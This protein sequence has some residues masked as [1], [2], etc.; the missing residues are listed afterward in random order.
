MVDRYS[1]ST[2]ALLAASELEE[3]LSTFRLDSTWKKS[4]LAFMNTWTTMV[5]DLDN[6]LIH[7]T[8]KSQK[9]I[10]LVRSIAPKALLA[11]SISQFKASEK[12]TKF[13][14]GTAY[15]NAPFSTL[16]DHVK[17]D[18]IHLD[19][20]KRIQQQLSSRKAHQTK[21]HSNNATPAP[22][23]PPGAPAASGDTFIGRDG[24]EYAYLIPP[25]TF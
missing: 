1:K 24:K 25:A 12:L 16:Y 19:Q 7:P 8:T 22:P 14:I 23:Q 17:D 5:L 21:I 15:T 11:M 20:T 4:C 6:F 3:G 18:A 9:R 10:W 13:A 2:A